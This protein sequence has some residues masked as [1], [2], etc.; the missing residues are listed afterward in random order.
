MTRTWPVTST[1]S[2]TT[3][4][5]PVCA[6]A[7]VLK[8]IKQWLNA[9]VVEKSQDRKPPTVRRN[10]KGTPQ[11][12][13]LSPLLANTYLHWFDHLF[14]RA[15][16][17]AQWAKAKLVRYAD[18][19]VV[20]ARHISPALKGWIESKLE[21]WLCLQINREKT[22][23]LD[24]QQN[25]Q[26]LNFLGYTFRYDRDLYGAE[27]RYWNLCPSHKTIL[28]EQQALRQMINHRQSHTPLP[29]LIERLNRHLRGWAN[30]FKLGYPRKA[31]TNINHFVGYTVWASTCA[32]AAREAGGRAKASASTLTCNT[33]D[34]S[35]C[36][37]SLEKTTLARAGWGKSP[38]PVRRGR[39]KRRSLVLWPFTPLLSSLLYW[40]TSTRQNPPIICQ[41]PCST[42][43]PT[44]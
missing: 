16:G 12:G 41:R 11:G 26:S 18:D 9:P 24:L 20:L 6:C 4:S 21:R 28:R 31:F 17:P 7:S 10:D 14:Q 8:L 25:S 23:V 37:C 27:R 36:E 30:Y 5:S 22:R 43:V 13:V 33:W 29:E 2:R 15:D 40:L 44:A 32:A 19:F 1:A 38:C 39:G 35:N 3:S 34:W 42:L